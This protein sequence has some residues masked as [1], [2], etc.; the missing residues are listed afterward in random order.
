M[1]Q[2]GRLS[3]PRQ[4][5]WAE[6]CPTGKPTCGVAATRASRS[7]TSRFQPADEAVGAD[8]RQADDRG[9][10][11]PAVDEHGL[12]AAGRHPQRPRR[13]AA[14][15]TVQDAG[16]AAAVV[17][18]EQVGPDVAR[19]VEVLGQRVADVVVRQRGRSRWR[20]RAPAR[21]PSSAHLV[22]GHR[23]ATV[24][25]APSN[26]SSRR[27]GSG[28]ARR[29]G[30]CARWCSSVSGRTRVSATEVMKLVSPAHRGSTCTWRWSGTPAPPAEP[31]FMP[32]FTPS[33]RVRRL[34]R[35]GDRVG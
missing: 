30:A 14:M 13:S 34:D 1:R 8:Q 19:G 15:T 26:R 6:A 29:P 27:G 5:I 31:R 28:R 3:R 24:A 23:P 35:R 18:R 12:V 7:S 9:H 11:K 4:P 10:R 22:V 25:A 16:D 2:V 20:A 32:T 21:A 17:V 33:Q